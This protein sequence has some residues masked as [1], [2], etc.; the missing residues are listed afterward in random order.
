MERLNDETAGGTNDGEWVG[1]KK[2]LTR[3]KKKIQD[4]EGNGETGQLRFTE[5]WRKEFDERKGITGERSV[6][7]MKTED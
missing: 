1:K 5:T 2:T 3:Q 6:T 4:I 7:R